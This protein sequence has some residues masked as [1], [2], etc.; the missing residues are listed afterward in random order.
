MA[1]AGFI[2]FCRATTTIAVLNTPEGVGTLKLAK[3]NILLIGPTGCGKTLLP[4][5]LQRILDVPFTMADATTLTPKQAIVGGR[6]LKTS[7]LK[8]F[9]KQSSEY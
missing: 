6:W 3:S 9:C 7:I 2:R 4:Q 5:R 1:Q 8:L